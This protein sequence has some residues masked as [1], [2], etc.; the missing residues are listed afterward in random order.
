MKCD[1]NRWDIKYSNAD[2]DPQTSSNSILLSTLLYVR[3]L[4]K[5]LILYWKPDV[6]Y[7]A[8]FVSVNIWNE[9]AGTEK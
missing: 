9:A 1:D 6:G 8:I 5:E 2:Y 4:S 7:I 3:R